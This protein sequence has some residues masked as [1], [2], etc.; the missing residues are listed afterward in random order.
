MQKNDNLLLKALFW[1]FHYPIAYIITTL[2]AIL[3]RKV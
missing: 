1:G 3:E 2:F